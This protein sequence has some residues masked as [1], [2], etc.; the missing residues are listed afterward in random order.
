MSNWA[1][2][3]SFL[4]VHAVLHV[5]GSLMLGHRTCESFEKTALLSRNV[6]QIAIILKPYYLLYIHIMVT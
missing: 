3:G 2:R 5:V 1:A 4:V 6:N